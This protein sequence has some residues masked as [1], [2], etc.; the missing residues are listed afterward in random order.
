MPIT[1][2]NGIDLCYEVSG[3]E[4]HPP[5]LLIC[6]LGMQMVSWGADLIAAVVAKGYYVITFDNRDAGLSTHLVSY[7]VP[8][9]LALLQGAEANVPYRLSDMADDVAG[10]LEHLELDS[11]HLVGVSMGGM[12]AQQVTID[13]PATARSL[14]SIMS[15]TGNASVGQ[16]SP[17]AG[18]ALLQMSSGSREEAIELSLKVSRII[19]SPGFPLDEARLRRLAA[20]EYDRSNEPTGVARQLGAI[21]AS[22][23]R[24]A[25]LA[26]VS[27]PTVAI[28][29]SA[30]R[31]VDP[32]GG[33]AT[34]NAVPDARLVIIDGMGH[35][36][37]QQVWERVLAEI[38]AN[39]RRGEA[40][41]SGTMSSKS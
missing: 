25:G 12:I 16:P 33:E 34:A 22:P 38:D 19:G 3:D 17:E 39:A 15:T 24:T 29:G 40:L 4:A 41:R 36:L 11:V 20:A 6:G 9:L 37:P 8:D 13:H 18:E 23:D 10:L 21:M 28:H 27:V 1:H 35:D 32:S 5:L 7:G 31:L 14:A 30:D 2:A 26:K